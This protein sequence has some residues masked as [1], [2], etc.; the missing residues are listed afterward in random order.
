[1]KNVFYIFIILFLTSC[2]NVKKETA[3]IKVL[4]EDTIGRAIARVDEG[5]DATDS[6]SKISKPFALNGIKCYW[7]HFFVL[8]KSKGDVYGMEVTMI[9]KT[10]KTKQVLLEVFDNPRYIED[11]DYK[12]EAYFDAINK[13][14]F[15][16]LNFDGFLDFKTYNKGSMPMTSVTNIYTFNGKTKL[17]EDSELSDNTIE[18]LDATNKILTTSSWDL[19]ARYTKKHHFSNNGK[20]KFSEYITEENYYPNDTTSRLIR[21]YQKMI[22]EEEV[23]IKVDTLDN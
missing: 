23:E 1:M 18:E 11:Y 4:H 3:V 6:L 19:N 10:F 9:L 8:Y 7:E 5:N 12:S 2:K 13:D 21:T 16:D 17:F 22:K 14:H 15:V 20:I